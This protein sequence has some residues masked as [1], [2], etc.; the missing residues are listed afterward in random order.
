M[1]IIH[2]ISSISDRDLHL[3]SITLTDFVGPSV[4]IDRKK[5][6]VKNAM[7][8]RGEL[9][10]EITRR[11]ETKRHFQHKIKILMRELSQASM[12]IFA[13]GEQS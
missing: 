10:L 7:E 13:K 2:N 4:T 6:Y 5:W 12:M 11:R 3:F 1:K 9:M 8:M